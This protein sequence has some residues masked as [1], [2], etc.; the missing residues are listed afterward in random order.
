MWW[1]EWPPQE[2][3][4]ETC[5]WARLL[6]YSPP[7]RRSPSPFS[8]FLWGTA[9][10]FHGV[11]FALPASARTSRSRKMTA[12]MARQTVWTGEM[13]ECPS[14]LRWSW[15]RYRRV[16]RAC[17][18]RSERLPCERA[19]GSTEASMD[20]EGNREGSTIHRGKSRRWK[21]ARTDWMEKKKNTSA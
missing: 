2:A 11:C 7:W 16:P 20:D 10:L 1:D 19:G 5:R 3:K 9:S 18:T 6:S 17:P 8:P 12:T 15:R 4:N 14:P 21:R 13:D